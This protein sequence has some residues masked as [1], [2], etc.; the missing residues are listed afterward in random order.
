[1]PQ[2]PRLGVSEFSAQQIRAANAV[3]P[4]TARQTEYS[5]WTR[6]MEW[7]LAQGDDMV[8]IPGTR[9]IERLKEHHGAPNVTFSSDELSEIRRHLPKETVGARYEES[10]R[11]WRSESR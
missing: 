10:V 4:I 1:M 11:T 6:N 3:H 9:S 2:A 7:V 5:L 8:V